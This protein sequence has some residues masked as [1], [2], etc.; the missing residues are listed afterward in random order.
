[1]PAA[2][3]AHDLVLT[4]GPDSQSLVASEAHLLSQD[5]PYSATLANP[6][7]MQAYAPGAAGLVAWKL[8]SSAFALQSTDMSDVTGAGQIYLYN[9]GAMQGQ[10]LL[11]NTRDFVWG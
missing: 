1:M 6:T 11:T 9:A 2:M 5:G 4:W 10:L 8:D 3:L 7:A